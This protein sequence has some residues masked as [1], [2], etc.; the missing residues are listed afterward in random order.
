MLPLILFHSEFRI[1]LHKG[2]E[3][4]YK[5]EIRQMI[6]EGVPEDKL[7]TFSFCGTIREKPVAGFRWTK[8][9]EFRYK[10]EMYDIVREETAGDSIVYHCIHD[11]KESGLFKRWESYLD[12]YLSK[13]PNKKSELLTTLQTFNQYYAPA[14][15]PGLITYPQ[16]DGTYSG[17]CLNPLPKEKPEIPKPPPRKLSC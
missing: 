7:V 15:A 12:D 11:V 4:K 17:T 10:G 14:E 3:A 5:R 9:N 16:S 8:K 1:I 6:K 13:N 2:M